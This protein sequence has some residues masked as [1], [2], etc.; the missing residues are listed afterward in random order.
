[1]ISKVRSRAVDVLSQFLGGVF[2]VPRDRSLRN[3]AVLLPDVP[4]AGSP[5]EEDPAVSVIQVQQEAAEMQQKRF[6]AT[7]NECE[8]EFPVKG[9]PLLERLRP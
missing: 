4:V 6:A 1:M 9:L 5:D 8:M 2:N 3:L 7:G